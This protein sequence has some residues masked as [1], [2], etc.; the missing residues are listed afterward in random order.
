MSSSVY[1]RER[2][3]LNVCIVAA[4]I[5]LRVVNSLGVLVEVGGVGDNVWTGSSC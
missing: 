1:L 2:A 4:Q 3:W 5:E